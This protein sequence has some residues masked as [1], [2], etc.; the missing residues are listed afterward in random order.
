MSGLVKKNDWYF[1]NMSFYI[2]NNGLRQTVGADGSVKPLI[3]RAPSANDTVCPNN[4]HRWWDSSYLEGSPQL[5][6]DIFLPSIN[7]SM[8]DDYAQTKPSIKKRTK[9]ANDSKKRTKA[10]GASGSMEKKTNEECT[11]D[12]GKRQKN[13]NILL[14]GKK[15]TNVLTMLLEHMWF[16]L[17]EYSITKRIEQQGMFHV[18]SLLFLHPRRVPSNATYT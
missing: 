1:P 18:K 12:A 7:A 5:T 3:I 15:L 14:F 17:K 9:N 4:C 2:I 13:M 10:S 11:A 8:P 6:T 16:H